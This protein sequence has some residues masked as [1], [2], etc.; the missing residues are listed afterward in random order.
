MFI[1]RFAQEE[2]YVGIIHPL[3]SWHTT[4]EGA[5]KELDERYPHLTQDQRDEAFER[6]E[7][8]VD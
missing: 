3:T 1:F 8:I 6:V 2:Q 7:V 4:I 5:N